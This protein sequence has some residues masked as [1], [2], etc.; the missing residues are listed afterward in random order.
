MR[1][2]GLTTLLAA[3][4]LTTPALADQQFCGPEGTLEIHPTSFTYKP[5][6]PADKTK[7][8]LT[9]AHTTF[10][11]DFLAAA[12]AGRAVG[13]MPDAQAHYSVYYKFTTPKWLG[14]K[15]CR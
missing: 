13:F 12:R 7:V 4:L 14:W 5:Y 3:A 9:T 11:H 15:E 2:I 1:T 10:G 8:A 6:D